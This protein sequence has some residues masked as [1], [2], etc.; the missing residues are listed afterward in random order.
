MVSDSATIFTSEEF[1]QFC[2]KARIFQK[3]CAPGHPASNGLA[4]RN[5][6]M[7]KHRL[8]TMSNQNMPFRQKVLEILFR[9]WSTPLSN[10][11]SPAE[12]YLNR[13]IRIQLDAMRSIKFHES[14]ATQPARRFSEGERVSARYYSNDKAFWECGKVLKKLES[15][16]F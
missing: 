13:Q 12:Q 2:K 1:A 3:F 10:G 16:I 4:E 9:Y 15:Y 11:K 8:A 5:V 6:Q 14:P 7:L